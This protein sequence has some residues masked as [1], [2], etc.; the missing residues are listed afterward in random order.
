MVLVVQLTAARS[1]ASAH[2]TG[3]PAG[4]RA[5]EIAVRAGRTLGLAAVAA[6]A[7]LV[8]APGQYARAPRLRKASKYGAI[9]FGRRETV[10]VSGL[11]TCPAAKPGA[12]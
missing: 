8:L 11:A 4:G 6:V 12:A 9:P 10:W 7:T 1:R 3:V 5:P 2:A